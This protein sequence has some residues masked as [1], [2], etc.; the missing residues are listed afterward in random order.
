M[1]GSPPV[2]A[3]TCVGG[4][5]T[6]CASLA[7]GGDVRVDAMTGAFLDALVTRS[8]SGQIGPASPDTV[9]APQGYGFGEDD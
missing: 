8:D 3:T 4:L 5:S 9:T 7:V 2:E 1:G 6:V